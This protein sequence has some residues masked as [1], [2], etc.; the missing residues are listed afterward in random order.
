MEYAFMAPVLSVLREQLWLHKN[1]IELAL[2][3]VLTPSVEQQ[4]RYAGP[5]IRDAMFVADGRDCSCVKAP[6]CNE[7]V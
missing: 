1:R 6:V 7:V 3:K 5:N 4:A 2:L